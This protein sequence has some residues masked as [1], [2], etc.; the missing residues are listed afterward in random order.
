MSFSEP[1]V[2]E[3]QRLSADGRPLIRKP[4]ESSRT[5][6]ILGFSSIGIPACVALSPGNTARAL[7]RVKPLAASFH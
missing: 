3:V 5:A 2:P 7:F 1:E 4:R 6:K